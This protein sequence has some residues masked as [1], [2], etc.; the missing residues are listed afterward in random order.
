MVVD[1]KESIITRE[2]NNIHYIV[3]KK[4]IISLK[5]LITLLTQIIYPNLELQFIYEIKNNDEIEDLNIEDKKIK[6]LIKNLESLY[7]YYK[8]SNG[9]L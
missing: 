3:D 6:D 9:I 4:N 8:I 1:L 7:V 5:S 2:Y